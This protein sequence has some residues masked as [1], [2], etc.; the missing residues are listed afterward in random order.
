VHQRFIRASQSIC[1]FALKTP[2]NSQMALTAPLVSV[3]IPCFNSEAYLAETIESVLNQTFKDWELILV[4]DGSTD[5]SAVIANR[6]AERLPEKI[7]CLSHPGKENKGVCA[8]RNL[9]VKNARGK[10]IAL[11]DSDDVWT[12]E[13]LQHQVALTQRFPECSMFCEAS[14]YWHSWGEAGK[15]DRIVN[16]GVPADQIYYPPHLAVNLYPLTKGAAPGPSGILMKKRAVEK[17]GGFEESFVGKYAFYEDQAFLFK[18]YLSETVFVSGACNNYYRVRPGSAM[19]GA[20]NK[21]N[22]KAVRHFFLKWAKA[23][24]KQN[25]IKNAGINKLLAKALE[26]YQ[27]SILRKVYRAL[28]ASKI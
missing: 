28:T 12:K 21:A 10:Y 4:D 8:S 11:L 1:R 19:S 23:Y 24:L 22:Y 17:V 2:I 3:V 7:V 5:K 27:T 9:G 6:Y 14:L 15:E 13:K 26:P 20:K 16:V 25:N 18:V